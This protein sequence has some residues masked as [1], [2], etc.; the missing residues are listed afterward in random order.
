MLPNFLICGIQK[1][2]TTSLYHYLKQHPQFYFPEKKEV[3]YF[4]FN[5]DKET[6]WYEAFFTDWLDQ[7]M[8]GEVSPLYMW[9]PEC[10]GRIANLLPDCQLIFALRCPVE[11]AYSNYWFNVSRGVQNPLQTFEAA[12]NTDYGRWAYLSKGYYAQQLCRFSEH[13]PRGSLHIVISEEL[14]Q[15]G[16]FVLNKLC[17]DLGISSEFSFNLTHRYNSTK[18]HKRFIFSVMHG[19]VF[20]AKN[21]IKPIF[22]SS[23]RPALRLLYQMGVSLTL[24]NQH[25]RPELEPCLKEMLMEHFQSHIAELEIFLGKDLTIWKR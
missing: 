2:G 23:F 17:N 5:F 19:L 8:I 14:Q 15:N 12:I 16:Q 9:Y 1:G 20:R 18:V 22:P 11:R 13:F 25:K 10:P 21:I 3:N 7:P 6:T 4:T 24:S